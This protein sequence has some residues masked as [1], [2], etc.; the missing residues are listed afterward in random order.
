MGKIEPK[1]PRAAQN[2]YSVQLA[3]SQK[4]GGN[5]RAPKSPSRQTGK[6]RVARKP[7]C[8]S[9]DER[10]RFFG[11]IKDVRNAALFRVIY[12]CC[13]RAS[14]AGLLQRSDYRM[15]QNLNG[16]KIRVTRKKGSVSGEMYLAPVAAACVRRWLRK[17]G[18]GPGP[19]FLSR[20]Q[21]RGL[22]R[23]RVFDL[24]RRYAIVAKLPP[25]K[26]HVHCLKHSAVTDLLQMGEDV[27]SAQRH[28]GHKSISSTMLYL[29]L[30]DPY[31]RA[32]AERLRDWR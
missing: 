25:E 32:R 23:S 29:H 4:S 14:E 21:G 31:D 16:D 30:A 24:F 27:T 8:L 15:G 11:V 9:E 28:A 20:Q 5:S 1:T 13:L 26:H 6:R 19:L 10:R 7:T 2:S 17:R 22:S 3:K 12:H 18:D